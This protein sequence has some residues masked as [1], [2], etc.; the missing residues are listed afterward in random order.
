VKTHFFEVG[1]GEKNLI[2]R[3]V[4]VKTRFGFVQFF[5]LSYHIVDAKY[6]RS[7]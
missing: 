7:I 2:V 5:P 6:G 1:G 3:Q 4:V